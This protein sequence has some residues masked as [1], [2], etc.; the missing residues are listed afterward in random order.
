M[1]VATREEWL[2]ARLA[3]LDREKA[4]L[5]ERDA[6][7]AA[8]RDLPW[9]RIDEAYSFDA[10]DD[11]RTGLALADLFDGR[12]QLLVYHFM[13]GDE[14]TEGCPSCSFWA[15]S[16]DGTGMHLAH[17]DVTLVAVSRGPV[18]TIRDY[19]Q[20]MGWSFPWY[21]SAGTP[22]N[23]DFGVRGRSYNYRPADPPIDEMPGLSAF[24]RDDGAV[25]HTYSCYSRGL[26][27]FNAAYQ[28]LDVAPKGRDEDSLPWPMAWL[29]RHD[30]YEDHA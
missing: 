30:A 16:F 1:T 2:T 3:L 13:L 6:L 8:R 19:K 14:W 28:L 12:R 10:V 5:R 22:F 20:R 15:D 21:S 23:E 18:E 17:R 25:Y 11:D 29:H 4:H 7:A 26:D 24:I 27:G 9:V